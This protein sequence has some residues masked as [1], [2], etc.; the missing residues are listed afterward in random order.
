MTY[1]DLTTQLAS[2]GLADRTTD[3]DPA[4]IEFLL[5]S[6]RTGIIGAIR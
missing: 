3:R 5:H 6:R 4:L 2:P 1:D